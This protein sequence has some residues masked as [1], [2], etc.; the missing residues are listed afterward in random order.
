MNITV[1]L[2]G[3]KR[4]QHFKKQLEAIENQTI[5]P[6]EILLWQ[7]LGENFDK[8]L[9]S[10]TTHSSCNKNL[11]VWARF[12][13]AL[14]ADTEY[15]CVFDDDTIP[16]KKWLENCLNT[17]Q[18]HDGLLG[19]IG[20]K[21]QTTQ[22]YHPNTRVGWANPNNNTEEVDIVGHS[23]FFKREWLSTFWREL[24]DVKQTRLVGEDMHFSYTLQ[25]Y[26]NK[27]TY[28][29]PHPIDDMEMWGSKPDTGWG[30]GQDSAALS[31][32]PLNI[33]LMS[34]EY[35]KYINRGFKPLF[36]R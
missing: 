20:V 22:S 16:G 4:S 2:N 29:P 24:P 32:F 35:Q 26:L 18:E 9:T 14:N 11:G 7:N 36:T 13:Y 8:H 5:K 25:K 12:A 1:I 28:V 10:R 3:F 34:M 6:K 21:F 17:I 15:V 27:K 33:S 31:M 30:I 19:T 23:W